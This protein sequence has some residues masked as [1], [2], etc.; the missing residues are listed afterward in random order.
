MGKVVFESK[1]EGEAAEVEFVLHL[2][3]VIAVAILILMILYFAS[4]YLLAG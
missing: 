1:P 4:L 2:S 3:A